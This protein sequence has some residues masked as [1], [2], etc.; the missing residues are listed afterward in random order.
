MGFKIKD[1]ILEKYEEEENFTE[2]IIPE[3]V[4][5]IGE[6]AF[7]GC[8]SIKSVEIPQNVNL[9]KYRAFFECENLETIKIEK[10][11]KSIGWWTFCEC[12]SLKEIT[13]PESIISIGENAFYKCSELKSITLSDNIKSIGENAFCTY[14]PLIINLHK[15]DVSVSIPITKKSYNRK[16]FNS[17]TEKLFD[18]ISHNTI[19]KRE[20]IFTELKNYDYKYPLSV[21]MSLAYDSDFFASYIKHSI[22]KADKY[23]KN[24]E[25]PLIIENI[26]F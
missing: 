7:A 20:W 10:G 21:F 14:N 23:K 2:I 8:K 17:E 13:I 24:N 6:N 1:N 5:E 15:N 19:Q 4:T 25:N 22:K 12:K 16:F 9:I 11:V 26:T 18:F 3:N